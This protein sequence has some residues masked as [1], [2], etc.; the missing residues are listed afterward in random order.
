MNIGFNLKSPAALVPN[1]GIN[2]SFEAL[3][4]SNNFYSLAMKDL[5]GIFFQYKSV[6]ST[7]KNVLFR[8]ATF[9][10]YFS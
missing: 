9:I 4:S 10:I 5:D 7:L 3:K 8:V 2:L 6:S 1:K